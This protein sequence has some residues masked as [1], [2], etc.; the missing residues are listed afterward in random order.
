MVGT[1]RTWTERQCI[2]TACWMSLWLETPNRA[3]VGCWAGFLPIGFWFLRDQQ[4][5]FSVWH[6]TS[7]K[8][9]ILSVKQPESGTLTRKANF[10]PS[11]GWEIIIEGNGLI[12]ADGQEKVSMFNDADVGGWDDRWQLGCIFL[13][14]WEFW[15]DLF[16]FLFWQGLTKEQ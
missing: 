12:K 8:G 11:E 5:V 14:V 6:H 16:H 4:G 15:F 1:V 7:K 3:M 13:G 10:Q 9:L 2:V